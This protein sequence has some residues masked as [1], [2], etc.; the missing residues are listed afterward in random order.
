MKRDYL[1]ADLS[2]AVAAGAA[3]TGTILL[4]TMGR[5]PDA[6]S[7]RGARASAQRRLSVSPAVLGR[8]GALLSLQGRY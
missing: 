5:K 2:L 1:I 3:I 6:G 7:D 4:L 8:S